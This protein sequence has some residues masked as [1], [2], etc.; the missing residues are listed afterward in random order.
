MR[1]RNLAIAKASFM[2]KYR[3]L[4]QLKAPYSKSYWYKHI[5]STR[6]NLDIHPKKLQDFD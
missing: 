2:I 3:L 6:E 5:V 4:D 1:I